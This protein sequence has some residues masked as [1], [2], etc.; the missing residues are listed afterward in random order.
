MKRLL[1]FLLVIVMMLTMVPTALAEEQTPA[2]VAKV[3]NTEYATIDEAIAAWTNGTTLTLLA[4]VT[5]SDA[6]TLNSTEHHILNL[7]T[8]TMT[9]ASGKNA[10]VIKACGTGSAERSAITINADA[11]NPG[12]INAGNRSIIYYKYADGGI[13]TEDRPIIKITGGVFT[14]STSSWGTAGIYTIG[15][16]ARKC[17]TLNITGGTFNC[18]IN[19]SGKS[20]LLISGGTFN[21]SVSSQGDSTCYRLISGGTFKTIGSMTADSNNTKFWIGTSMGNSDVGV[22][23]DD[24]GYIAVGGP[25]IITAGSKYKASSTYSGANSYLQY[26][27]AKDNGLY[28]TSVEEAL[29]DNNK[30]T[31]EVTVYVDE[32]DLTNSANF[33][34]TIVLAAN[35]TSLTVPENF[36][37]KIKLGDDVTKVTAPDGLSVT[38]EKEGY[39]VVET[40]NGYAVVK[41]YTVT[42]KPGNSAAETD[43]QTDTK[44]HDVDITLKDAIFTRTG[45]TQVGWTTTDNGAKAYEL[46]AIYTT[47]EAITLY[48]AWKID[49]YTITFD[50]DGGNNIDTITQDYGTDVTAPANPTKEG[51][52]FAGWDKTIPAT[53]PAE[54]VTIKAQWQINQYTIT[55]DTDGGSAI[56]PITQDYGTAVNAPAAPTKD[57]YTFAGWDKE[58]PATMPAENVTIKALWT[59]NQ[60]T[61][62]FDTDGGSDIAPITQNYGTDVIAPAN[63]TKEGYTFAG[64]DNDIP[65]TMP[66]EN[67]TIT[68]KWT[69]NEYSIIFD[70]AGGSNID[71][72]AQDYGTAVTAPAAPTK[73]G[74]TFAGWDEE[75]PATMPAETITITAKWTINQYTITFMDGESEIGK[76]TQDYGAPIVAPDDPEKAGFKFLGWDKVIPA[77]MPAENITIS[78]Q[79]IKVHVITVTSNGNGSVIYRIGEETTPLDMSEGKNYIYAVE[80]D[81]VILD[82]TPDN[83][84]KINSVTIDGENVSDYTIANISADAEVDIAFKRKS[85]GFTP[86]NTSSSTPN[87]PDVSESEEDADEPAASKPP[88]I[89]KVLVNN[90]VDCKQDSSCILHEFVDVFKNEWY[91]D[92]IHYCIENGLMNG[93]SETEFAPEAGTSRA[94]IVT[95]LWRMA[96]EPVVNSVITFDDVETDEW[97]TEAIRW[98][99]AEGIVDGYSA[100]AFGPNDDIS[101]EQL[102]T[103][104]WRYAKYV[105]I[106]TSGENEDSLGFNDAD[107]VSD[108]ALPAMQWASST[109]MVEGKPGNLL[110]PIGGARRCETA[111]LMMRFCETILQ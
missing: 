87:T 19:G 88:E 6:I 10:I 106:N 46:N 69:T 95:I 37:G 73:E 89:S 107:E 43:E 29:A 33:K 76:I 54:N 9:A 20:K 81:T 39:T 58:I 68:A 4:D 96:G 90:A 86:G 104:L 3:G 56:A 105:S 84:Y 41:A 25:V 111:T 50:T 77:T 91:H 99:A 92:G 66:A 94:M 5:L 34:G 53:M 30:A 60:Y 71:P 14:G 17:A 27:S 101:R 93:V 70:T 51:Y 18:S 61:I 57:G 45:Y 74:Y 79:F 97:Y 64:W 44:A 13:S 38:T 55:F 98:A 2:P 52:T 11:T 1:A 47:N 67:M 12:G 8:H 32:L 24:N 36:T 65:T 22:H 75:I 40:T 42:Y 49:Q 59:I 7:G 72:I 31:G 108:W 82:I 63:P 26:S 80:G 16:A 28:Y 102:A 78:A 48:P 103:I 100:D 35:E 15:T 110:D 85:S 21:Y 62:T 109:G 83:G 23:V